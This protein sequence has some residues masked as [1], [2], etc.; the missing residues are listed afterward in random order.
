MF[1][2][3]LKSYILHK[4]NDPIW[5]YS[6]ESLLLISH[7]L[8]MHCLEKSHLIEICISLHDDLNKDYKLDEMACFHV[9]EGNQ[10]P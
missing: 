7:V 1:T 6:I 4:V 5:R 3:Y 9:K 8:S 2:T 10:F